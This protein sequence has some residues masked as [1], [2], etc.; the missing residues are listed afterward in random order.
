[1]IFPNKYVNLKRQAG[2]LTTFTAVLI[3]L[4]LT[5]MMVFAVR[6]GVFEQRGSADNLRQKNAFHVAEA[7]IQQAKHYLYR[8]SIMVASYQ[9]DLLADGTNGWLAPGLEQWQKCS[10]V[11]LSDG[12]GTHP[13]YGESDGTR[14]GNS[15]YYSVNG[16]TALPIDTGSVLQS[17]TEQVTVEAVMCVMRLD[18][19]ADPP[20]Q[21]CRRIRPWL[22]APT[23]WSRCW[24][25]VKPTVSAANAVRRRW[26]Q[27]RWRISG[28]WVVGAG[29]RYR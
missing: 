12:S 28:S 24:R 6:V 2:V 5:L 14:R 9:P 16:N 3:L 13:C 7:G 23:S 19:E 18:F 21:E 11:S 27:S 1:M 22:T 4:M 15:Y 29:P 25:G 10:E 17:A 20:F 26:L 8:N